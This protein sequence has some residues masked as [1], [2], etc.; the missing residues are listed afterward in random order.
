MGVYV[1]KI[2]FSS[3]GDIIEVFN[4]YFSNYARIEL[5]PDT[6]VAT[7]F[8]NDKSCEIEDTGSQSIWGNS[9]GDFMFFINTEQDNESIIF[10]RL[11]TDSSKVTMPTSSSQPFL[12]IGTNLETKQL[13]P[14]ILSRYSSTGYYSA[15]S[16]GMIF[17]NPAAVGQD[18]L[19]K[20]FYPYYNCGTSAS[21]RNTGSE[22]LMTRMGRI[23]DNEDY[24]HENIYTCSNHIQLSQ[25]VSCTDG[26][27]YF[28]SI[29]YG[30]YIK[31]DG[32][33][34]WL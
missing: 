2:S 28:V 34:T 24:L 14:M 12:I 9:F 26:N 16:E 33:V 11:Q 18:F 15:Q 19:N 27:D 5:N 23:C 6:K 10:L 17:S 4:N 1:K 20:Y 31:S 25:G 21:W 8:I 22:L 3:P 13:Q 7:F 30:M 32:Q 29:G